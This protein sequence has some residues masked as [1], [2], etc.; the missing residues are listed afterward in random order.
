VVLGSC[1]DESDS[2]DINLL[3]GLRD[4]N[5]DLGNGILEGVQVADNVVDLVDVLLGEV[6]LVGGKVASENPGVD[7]L[8]VSNALYYARQKL[9][10]LLT[11]G[12]RVLT[13]PASISGACVMADT[14]STSKPDSLI[15]RAVPPDARMR[16]L[17]LIRPLARSSRPVLS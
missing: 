12:W 3:D 7:L 13:R 5:V 9:C 8:V 14:S 11:A 17:C 4:R 16:T 1:S 2:S 15:M 10:Q 6:L